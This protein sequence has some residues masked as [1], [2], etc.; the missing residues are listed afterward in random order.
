[1]PKATKSEIL[2]AAALLSKISDDKKKKFRSLQYCLAEELFYSY[3]GK[4]ESVDKKKEFHKIALQ[5]RA[6]THYRWW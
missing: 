5:N 4:G 1:M 2:T 6:Y 3:R